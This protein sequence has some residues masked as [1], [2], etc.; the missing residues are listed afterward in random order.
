MSWSAVDYLHSNTQEIC[1][2]LHQ[3]RLAVDFFYSALIEAGKCVYISAD[4]IKERE[5]KS[6]RQR[7]TE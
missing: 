7:E 2:S 6:L 1:M 5:S 3:E 4:G